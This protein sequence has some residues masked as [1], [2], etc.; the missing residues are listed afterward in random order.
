M[1][2]AA[3]A[4]QVEVRATAIGTQSRARVGFG[5]AQQASG[6]ALTLAVGQV[7]SSL[8]QQMRLN[9]APRIE[10]Q[11]TDVNATIL[12]LNAGARSGVKTGDRLPVRR[13]GRVIGQVV[14]N[15]VEDTYSVGTYEGPDSPRVGDAVSNQLP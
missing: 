4:E 7:A 15:S 5:Q 2:K 13:S 1:A 8:N 10:A 12:T 6:M 3:A 9:I 14:I 11:V